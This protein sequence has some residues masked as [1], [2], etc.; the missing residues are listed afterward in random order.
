METKVNNNYLYKALEEY[1]DSLNKEMVFSG[2]DLYGE[3]TASQFLTIGEEAYHW[4]GH[5]TQ[6]IYERIV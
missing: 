6:A 3:D 1:A 5:T 4:I 2:K